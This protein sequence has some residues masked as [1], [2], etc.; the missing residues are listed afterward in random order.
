MRQISIL[1][2]LAILSLAPLSSASAQETGAASAAQADVS[3]EFTKKRYKVKGAWTLEQHDG[4]IAIR[5]SQDFKTKNG[6]DLKILLSPKPLSDISGKTA[7]TDAVNIGVLKSNQG[8]QVYTIPNDINLSD[9]KSVIV[10]CEAFSV[11]WG[12]FDIPE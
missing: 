9:Y 4:R 10:H 2:L 5:F 7:M 12:G 11:L 1:A 3:G 6:P 8:E